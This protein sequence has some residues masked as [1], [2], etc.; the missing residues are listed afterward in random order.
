MAYD[1]P[2]KVYYG[3]STSPTSS[4]YRIY[5]AP[6]FNVSTN[7]NYA[8]DSL[9]GYDYT[10][11]LNGYIT[12]LDMVNTGGQTTGIDILTERIDAVS[13]ILHFNGGVLTAVDGGGS[14]VIKAKGGIL[15][16]FNIEQSDNLWRDY[17][18]FTAELRFNEIEYFNC[19]NGGAIACSGLVYDSD[20]YNSSLVDLTKYK[21]SSFNDNWTFDLN[22]SNINSAY[23]DIRNE[24]INVQYEISANGKLFFN[25]DKVLPAWEQ[26]KNFVQDRL[27]SQV[28]SLIRDVLN[29]SNNANDGC[30]PSKNISTIHEESSSNDGII[31]LSESNYKVYNETITCNTSESEG[32]FSATYNAVLKRSNTTALFDPDCIHTFNVNKTITHKPNKNTTIVVNGTI[33]GL[34]EGGLINSPSAFQFPNS[35]KLLFTNDSS[36]DTTKYDSALSAYKKISNNDDL[37]DTFKQFLNIDYSSL[38]LSSTGYPKSSS[39]SVNHSYA[40]GTIS[41]ITNFD[42][43]VS[44]FDKIPI[45][46]ISIT[47]NDPAP[48]IAEF[49]IPGRSGGPIIQRL[50][51]DTPKTIDINITGYDSGL[52]NCCFDPGQIVEDLCANSALLPSVG[53]PDTSVSGLVLITNSYN[54]NVVDGSFSIQRKYICCN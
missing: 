48:R 50:G 13:K 16:N 18:P 17:A 9:I 22:D 52:M 45:R 10:V 37:K 7:Y 36:S 14:P 19:S 39:H 53:I 35:G 43:N 12:A 2:I 3:P 40:N 20:K 5:P 6:L 38:G 54:T 28:T 34:I 1:P 27:H 26:A 44:C 25:E 46:S 42:S 24:S 31:N 32:S 47:E 15:Q 41:Y 8:N 30:S 23:N 49:I 33:E 21:I 11:T 4:Q 51:S 29:K